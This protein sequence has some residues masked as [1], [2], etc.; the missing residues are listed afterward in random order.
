MVS[1]NNSRPPS[2]GEPVGEGR[3]RA[4]VAG[5]QRWT[6]RTRWPTASAAP[7][8]WA[9]RPRI[10]RVGR[11]QPGP[12]SDDAHGPGGPR[13]TRLGRVCQ[14]GSLGPR[15][16]RA[17]EA[18]REASAANSSLGGACCDRGHGH[19]RCGGQRRRPAAKPGVSGP[20][21][22]ARPVGGRLALISRPVWPATMRGWRSG[23]ARQ[24]AQTRRAA[25]D[26]RREQTRSAGS[27]PAGSES[28]RGGGGSSRAETREG[29]SAGAWSTS[30]AN[31]FT[32]RSRPGHGRRLPGAAARAAVQRGA[33]GRIGPL[34]AAH[35]LIRRLQSPQRPI[36]GDVA[37]PVL[38]VGN[39]RSAAHRHGVRPCGPRRLPPR[40]R[41]RDPG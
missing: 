7:S 30:T 20:K 27:R 35:V 3:R 14:Q 8:R 18:S 2:L 4:A 21:G 26:A 10:D 24:H 17:G 28:D 1:R 22:P 6:L 37:G 15:G 40:W 12:S 36:R 34:G 38:V 25:P 16:P 13:R 9:T 5:P 32:V 31:S 33:T 23:T 11:R 39:R 29:Q 41:R 19:P